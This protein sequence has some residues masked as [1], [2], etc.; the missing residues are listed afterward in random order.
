MVRI[1]ISENTENQ[2][3]DRFLRKYFPKA[4]LSHIYM[5]IRKDLKLNGKRAREDT[6]LH[7]GDEVVIYM[8]DEEAASLMRKPRSVK[9]KRQ[10]DIAYEDDNVLIVNKPFGLLTH[11]DSQEKKNHLTNQV[12]A[13][14]IEKGQYDPQAERS[15][16]PS[17]ANRIDRNTTGLVIFAKDAETLRCLNAVLRH[18]EG[19][20]KYYLTVCEGRM[21]EGETRLTGYMKKDEAKNRVTVS[22][23][24]DD[25]KLMETAVTPIAYSLPGQGSRSLLLVQIF[26]GRTHQIRAQLADAGHPLLG[27]SKYGARQ[28][29]IK[30][31]Q[32]LHS[33][34]LRF[35]DMGEG[36]LSYLTGKTVT[37]EPPQDMMKIIGNLFGIKS[38][39]ELEDTVSDYF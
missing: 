17:P 35:T 15:F 32:L 23:S 38:A 3:L 10:F 34:K 30:S 29:G 26:T 6:L 28:T 7:A 13:Y 39:G 21:P 31:T 22:S 19:I 8:S 2:R 9:A 1:V 37:A 33:W 5:M 4:S 14:L 24:P 12:I 27:D 16:A 11:G 25:G 18:K 20:E 36:K